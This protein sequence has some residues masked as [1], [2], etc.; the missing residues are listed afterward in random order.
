MCPLKM[1]QDSEVSKLIQKCARNEIRENAYYSCHQILVREGEKCRS[2]KVLEEIMTKKF[3]SANRK[4]PTF[5]QNSVNHKQA[6][7]SKLCF[8]IIT[9]SPSS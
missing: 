5:S 3:W 1:V 4:K 2:G 9:V 7:L 8:K 6:N